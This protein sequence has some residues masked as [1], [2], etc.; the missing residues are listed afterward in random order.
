VKG[1][2]VVDQL[3]TVDLRRIERIAGALPSETMVKVLAKLR[4]MFAE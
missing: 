2:V 1:H 3:R 4:E